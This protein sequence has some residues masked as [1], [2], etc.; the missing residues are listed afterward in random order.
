MN[1]IVCIAGPS[2]SGKSTLIEFLTRERHEY[3]KIYAATTRTLRPHEIDRKHIDH[4]TFQQ[5]VTEDKIVLPRFVYNTW[6]GISKEDISIALTQNKI[7][8]LDR[9]VE[10]IPEFKEFFPEHRI[11]SIYLVPCIDTL[12]QRL[13]RRNLPEQRYSAALQELEELQQGTY[14]YLDFI[15]Q[16]NTDSSA[17]G[18]MVNHFIK[19]ATLE[20][21]VQA[22]KR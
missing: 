20:K 16:N 18:D 9:P 6:Y 15:V 8:L 2:G 11:L 1:P 14:P 5:L 21:H 7:P 4:A 22:Q 12:Q 19:T 13:Q 3:E 17:T 10:H